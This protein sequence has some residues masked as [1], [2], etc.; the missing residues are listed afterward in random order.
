MLLNSFVFHDYRDTKEKLCCF[1]IK[2]SERK[3][4]KHSRS[5]RLCAESRITKRSIVPLWHRLHTHF[6]FVKQHSH[7]T[8]LHHS[9]RRARILARTL[10]FTNIVS[11]LCIY[12][13]TNVEEFSVSVCLSTGKVAK[14]DVSRTFFQSRGELEKSFLKSSGTQLVKSKPKIKRQPATAKRHHA[15]SIRRSS[16]TTPGKSRKI[17]RRGEARRKKCEKWLRDT[18][19]IA[20]Q[21][22]GR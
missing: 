4:A 14:G 22:E 15:Q 12:S 21:V 3:G 17:F 16:R 10:F 6:P 18:S 2:S 9:R 8:T 1:T 20:G 19:W 13:E 5:T 7:L 11:A